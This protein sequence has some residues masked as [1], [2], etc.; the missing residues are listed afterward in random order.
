MAATIAE[1]SGR[2]NLDIVGQRKSNIE[3]RYDCGIGALNRKYIEHHHK[4]FC[5]LL[6]Q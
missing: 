3:S 1:G 6:K 2:P 4:N 5:F